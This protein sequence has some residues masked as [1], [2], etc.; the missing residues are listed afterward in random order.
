MSP[1]LKE[2]GS[3]GLRPLGDQIR[4]GWGDIAR[5]RR[6]SGEGRCKGKEEEEGWRMERKEEEDGRQTERRRS[7]RQ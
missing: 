4:R 3:G 7:D 2:A 1:D 5:R 6:G